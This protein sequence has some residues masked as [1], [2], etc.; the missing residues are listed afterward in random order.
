MSDV[1]GDEPMAEVAAA[2]E[3]PVVVPSGIFAE[4]LRGACP[5]ISKFVSGFL[6]KVFI[7]L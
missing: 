7:G 2:D 5:G 3:T 1:E 6:L 4:I